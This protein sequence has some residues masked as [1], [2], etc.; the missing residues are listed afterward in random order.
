MEFNLV[1]GWYNLARRVVKQFLKV[2]DCE[3]GDTNVFNLS[4]FRKLLH[5]LPEKL[6]LGS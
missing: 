6:S 1:Y 5:F 3:I 2:F 4:C